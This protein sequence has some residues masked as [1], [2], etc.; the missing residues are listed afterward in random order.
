MTSTVITDEMVEKAAIAFRKAT[1][2][3]PENWPSHKATRAALEAAASMI[4]EEA[5]KVAEAEKLTGRPPPQLSSQ[6][7]AL[8]MGA[9]EATKKSIADA[10]H[11]R[12]KEIAP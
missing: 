3:T 8:V 12:A 4:L 6:E 11:A 7:I 1:L 5:A 2:G 10:L 9:V